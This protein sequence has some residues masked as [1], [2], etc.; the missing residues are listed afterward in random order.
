MILLI[1][2]KTVED[3]HAVMD[4]LPL[5]RE[6][7]MNHEYIPVGPLAPLAALIAR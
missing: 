4:T 5:T 7:L 1:D 6:N 3:A 2:A